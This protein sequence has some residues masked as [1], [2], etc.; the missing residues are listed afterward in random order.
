MKIALDLSVLQS[1]HRFRGIGTVAVNFVNNLTDEDKKEN[2]FIFF[3]KKENEKLAYELLNLKDINYKTRYLHPRNYRQFPNKLCVLSKLFYK[4]IG[5][6]E[7]NIGDPRIS[8][9]QLIDVDKYIQFDQSQKL[10]RNASKNTILF[11]YDII[12]YI[13]ESDYLWSF[14]TTRQR[15]NSLMSSLKSAFKR[16][17]YIERVRINCRRAKILITASQHAKSEFIKY[18]NAREDKINVVL[19]GV[20]HATKPQKMKKKILYSYKTTMWGVIKSKIDL[21]AKPFILFIGGTDQRRQ[22]VELIAAYN[23][24]RA[25]GAN[26]SLVLAGDEMEGLESL[27][28]DNMK[29]YLK[30][31]TSYNDNIYL[32][33]YVTNSERDWLYSNTLCF[34]FPS[35]YEG[36]GLPILEAMSRGAPV[37]TYE[38]SS[39]VEV[40]G[41]DVIYAN[42]CIEIVNAIQELINNPAKGRALSKKGITRSHKFSWDKTTS[43]IMDIIR[44]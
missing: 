24:L 12:P 7:Y 39:I 31:N 33:G 2:S 26:I 41:Q 42:G 19:L 14:S 25:R 44:S 23:N 35:L 4:I 43:A 30:N 18:I 9:N 6:I 40:G 36:F 27:K 32:M 16:Y 8:R 3:I 28:N 15:G 29:G 11:V 5:F 34:V 38:N 17:Q 37:V 20:N 1:H 10:P 13:L 21:T 22:M